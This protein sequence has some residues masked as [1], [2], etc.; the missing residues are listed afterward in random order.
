MKNIVSKLKKIRFPY[1]RKGSYLCL[2]VS[3]I[4]L[5]YLKNYTLDNDTWFLLNHGRYVFHHGIPYIEPFTIHENFS[6]VMQQWLSALI[7][8]LFYN[9][10]GIKSLLFLIIFLNFVIIFVCYKLCMLLSDGNY[11]IA[12]ILTFFI[13]CSLLI[14]FIVSRPQIFTFI[15]VLLM[16]YSL[17]LYIK[18]GNVKYLFILPIIS[19]LQ[20]NLHASMWWML[21]VLML[22]YLLDGYNFK[23]F[24]HDIYKKW[25]IIVAMIVM[26]L[27][28]FINPY[29]L[30]AIVYF[31]NSYGVESINN[32][33]AEM[34]PLI[35]TDFS[36][37]F[38]WA[39]IFFIFILY[40]FVGKKNIRVRYLLLFIGTCYLSLSSIKGFSYLV[41]SSFFPFAYY[42]KNSLKIKQS[43]ENY[44]FSYKI[45]FSCLTLFL[46]CIFL[47]CYVIYGVNYHNKLE[48]GINLLLEKYDKTDV[49]LYV[50]Y[51][52]GGYTEFRGIKSYIDPRAEVFLKENN[53][54]A[55]IFQEYY[56]LEDGK[57]DISKFL[58]KYNFTH[59][60]ITEREYLYDKI[61]DV[62]GYSLFYKGKI[63]DED[64]YKIYV[65][66][67][68]KF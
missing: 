18:K 30:D 35:V 51:S 38:I 23:N 10:F 64:M 66:N 9:Y 2:F 63:D 68:I 33:V 3:T 22:P 40:I 55:D 52:Q 41:L 58:D 54:M 17:E 26:F 15:L 65:R 4:F 27:V 53:K 67:D 50:G 16:F 48:N 31:F 56:D 11:K 44:N 60:L 37:K 1:M 46:V 62:G 28:A 42:F 7:F 5:V 21:Y 29:G 13:D 36:G 59:L 6:F 34:R 12:S 45:I 24:K 49:K 25:P 32:Y 43:K 57:I 61:N 8:Y 20:I 19:L 14:F 39:Y 47:G